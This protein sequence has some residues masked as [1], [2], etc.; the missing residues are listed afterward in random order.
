[1][2]A[3]FWCVVLSA[4]AVSLALLAKYNQGNVVF[5]LAPWRIDLSLNFFALLFISLFA[6]LYVTLRVMVRTLEFPR[7]VREYRT[8]RESASASS[9]LRLALQAYFEGRHSRTERLA[10]DIRQKNHDA[11]LAALLAAHSAHRRQAFDQRD[12]WLAQCA[13]DA[14]LR[15]ARLISEA[16]L[17][18]EAHDTE[19]A[20]ASIRELHSSGARHVHALRLELQ[21]YQQAG[22][23]EDVI[24][25]TRQLGKRQAL[26]PVVLTKARVQAYVELFSR[27]A[28][29]IGR[30]EQLWT[31]IS[32]P[33][34][35]LPELA[36]A[37]AQAFSRAGQPAE[38]VDI[39][40]NAL[41]QEWNHP[42]LKLYAHIDAPGYLARQ[43]Q[44]AESWLVHQ[45][46]DA[47][48]LLML[49]HLCVRA[50]LWGKAADYLQRSLGV[51]RQPETLFALAQLA[52]RH[53]DIDKAHAHY[54]DCALLRYNGTPFAP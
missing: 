42:L 15:T 50:E 4:A 18:L 22:L 44:R 40:E 49:G 10:K 52:E 37:A 13:H 34:R 5:V 32:T 16:E 46:Q 30:V 41:A 36:Y 53:G 38:A 31:T 12:E 26:H 35:S 1:M 25:L 45:P 51:E 9:T 20:L 39:I 54:R 43:I 14:S 3:L 17:R 11:G 28:D 47:W 27:C 8:Q 19:A 29:D 2:R 23:W 33:D 21:G 7:K 6:L 24:R 48:L